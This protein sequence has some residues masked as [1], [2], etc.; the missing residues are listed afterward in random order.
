MYLEAE[1]TDS[2]AANAIRMSGEQVA[3]ALARLSPAAKAIAIAQA[4]TPDAKQRI[5]ALTVDVGS[6]PSTPETLAGGTRRLNEAPPVRFDPA[7]QVRVFEQYLQYVELSLTG[8]AIQRHRLAIPPSIQKLGGSEDLEKR[9]RTTFDLIEKGSKLSSK[10]LEDALNEIRKNLTPSL[11]KDHGRV[12]LKAAKPRL[13]IRLAEFRKKLEAHQKTVEDELQKH[14]D[15]SRELIV[16]YYKAR[17]IEADP[18]EVHGRSLNG[19]IT[20]AGAIRWLNT[21]LDRVFPSAESLI[22]EMKRVARYKDVT[23]ETLNREGFL[24][25]VIEGVDGV[26]W[27]KAFSGVKSAGEVEKECW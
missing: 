27:D 5:E 7:R 16:S 13:L 18:D 9:L 10:P 21:Q 2:N 3:H 12:V 15:A 1:R 22:K 23:F 20:E 6:E 4:E 14:L 25:L 26:G 8:A 11:G 24:D 17:V 19:K